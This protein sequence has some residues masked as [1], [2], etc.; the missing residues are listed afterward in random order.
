MSRESSTVHAAAAAAA[1]DRSCRS[2][3]FKNVLSQK[4]L[5]YKFQVVSK[6][7]RTLFCIQ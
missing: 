6:L 7:Y 1:F 4:Y 5:L 3:I 2:V